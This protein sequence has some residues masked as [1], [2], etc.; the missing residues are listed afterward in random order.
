MLGLSRPIR[1]RRRSGRSSGVQWRADGR[2]VV[3]D[4]M[5]WRTS[6]KSARHCWRTGSSRAS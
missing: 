3:V 6:G 5:Q 2:V 4:G 1:D